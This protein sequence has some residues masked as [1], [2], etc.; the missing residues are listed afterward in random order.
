M[1]VMP[2]GTVDVAVDID[3]VWA[4][5]GRIP[6][7]ANANRVPGGVACTDGLVSEVV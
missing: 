4:V 6:C 1:I 7:K 3:I 5:L 2:S